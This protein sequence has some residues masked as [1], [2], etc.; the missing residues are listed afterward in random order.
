MCSRHLKATLSACL[1]VI[2]SQPGDGLVLL[3]HVP[4]H[5]RDGGVG[6]GG[7][8]PGVAGAVLIR[9]SGRDYLVLLSGGVHEYPPDTVGGHAGLC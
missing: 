7:R 2:A 1:L 3:P 8:G 4:R 5:H 9:G 6:R